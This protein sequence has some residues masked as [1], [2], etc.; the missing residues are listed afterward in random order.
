MKFTMSRPITLDVIL[1]A[2]LSRYPVDIIRGVGDRPSAY[3]CAQGAVLRVELDPRGHCVF[4]VPVDSPMPWL[5]F[6]TLEHAL[7]CTF[8]RITSESGQCLPTAQHRQA[9]ME[10]LD[11]M[12]L[13][14]SERILYYAYD[15]SNSLDPDPSVAERVQIA[16][17]LI[18]QN[19]ALADENRAQVLLLLV[20]DAYLHRHPPFELLL[21]AKDREVVKLAANAMAAWAGN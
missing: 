14:P 11:Q 17:E 4:A 10:S 12:D 6:S 1:N 2:D 5:V 16:G 7:D 18:K 15:S 8:D 3:L 21:R 13:E 9:V 20:E 19:P